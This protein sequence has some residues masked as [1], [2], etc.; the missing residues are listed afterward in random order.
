MNA[1]P[2]KKPTASSPVT[3]RPRIPKGYRPNN[4]GDPHVERVLSITM[5]VATE[6]AV[7]HDTI[8]T[9]ARLSAAQG[10]FSMA[11]IEAYE[12]TPEVKAAREKWRKDYLKRLLRI[13]WEDIPDA[14]G[15]GRGTSYGN[16]VREISE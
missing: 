8:D 14:P 6:V 11:E 15:E 10:K 5:A 12:P 7:L 9:M 13:L 4:L 1:A 3:G 2:P 16:I